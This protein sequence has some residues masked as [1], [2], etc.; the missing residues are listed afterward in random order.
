VKTIEYVTEAGVF[1][2]TK[3][4]IR[5]SLKYFNANNVKSSLLSTLFDIEAEV[6]PR[7]KEP[8]AFIAYGGGFGHGVGM[9]QTGAAG[10]A[11]KGYTFDQILSRYYQEIEL[12]RWY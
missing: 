9:C 3:D 2:D 12:T 10:M 7:T 1:T 4:R 8:L 6:D 11:E 5:T